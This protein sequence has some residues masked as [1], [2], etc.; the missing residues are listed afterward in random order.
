MG[1]MFATLTVITLG[2][3]LWSAW[4]RRHAWRVRWETASTIQV[5][6]M[7]IGGTLGAGGS[8]IDPYLHAITHVW[9]L[10][11]WLSHMFML[12]ATCAV[13][14][15]A[16]S[17]LDRPG[18]CPD[19][20]FKSWFRKWIQIPTAVGA[21]LVTAL[22]CGSRAGHTRDPHFGQGKT[23]GPYLTAYWVVLSLLLLYLMIHGIRAFI[24]LWDE[25]G[26]GLLR[27]YLTGC[28]LAVV[29]LVLR[30]ILV[31]TWT[32]QMGNVMVVFALGSMASFA[33]AAGW[34]WIKRTR[35]FEAD[36]EARRT[37][38]G[39]VQHDGDDGQTV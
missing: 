23:I 38:F 17:R 29:T 22:F 2:I 30:L 8:L 5:T 25:P 1:K 24:D 16:V 3:V 9:N 13:V 26:R 6:L 10:H 28:A 34:S 21:L 39:E 33:I 35:W 18:R 19:E 32:Q 14:Y 12:A 11:Y 4:T 31:F 7:A 20:D 36:L 27:I 15:N 37:H